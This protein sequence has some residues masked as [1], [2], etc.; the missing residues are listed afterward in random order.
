MEV[1][2][3]CGGGDDGLRCEKLSGGGMWRCNLMA[4]SG[5]TLCVKHSVSVHKEV[6]KSQKMG[7]GEFLPGGFKKRKRGEELKIGVFN[8]VRKRPKGLK[9]KMKNKV[10]VQND[11]GIKI[12]RRGRPKG[13]KNK[14]KIGAEAMKQENGVKN[15][16]VSKVGEISEEGKV[17]DIFQDVGPAPMVHRRRVGRPKGSKNKK[18][19]VNNCTENGDYWGDNVSR[20][21]VRRMGRPKGSK[22]KKK[23]VNEAEK[24][25][26]NGAAKQG[27]GVGRPKGYNNHKMILSPIELTR[28]TRNYASDGDIQYLGRT[29]SS[30]TTK[31]K[32]IMKEDQENIDDRDRILPADIERLDDASVAEFMLK[33]KNKRDD[34]KKKFVAVEANGVGLPEEDE[35]YF[36]SSE[37]KKKGRG[38]PKKIRIE[39]RE[40]NVGSQK[41]LAENDDGVKKR[42]R[43]RPKKNVNES[44]DFACMGEEITNG[45]VKKTVLSGSGMSDPTVQ[46]EQRGLMCHQCLKSS[47]DDV[48]ICSNCNKKRYCSECIAKWYPKKTKE[49]VEKSCP[50]CCGNCNCRAC[51]QADVLL[52]GCQ[53]EADENIRLQRSLYLL[54][55]V[56]PLLRLIQLEQTNELDV[57]TSIRGV[58]MNEEDVQVAVCEEDDRVYCD[59]CKTSIV[60]FHRSCASAACS[61]DI[62]LDCCHELRKGLQPGGI[63]AKSLPRPAE[64]TLEIKNLSNDNNIEAPKWEAMNNGSI[65]CPPEAHGGCGTHILVLKR[66]FD[67]NWV[68]KLIRAAEEFT[69]NYQLPDIDFSRKCLSCV[70]GDEFCEVRKAADRE[71]SEDNFLYCPDAL[72]MGDSAF[73]HFQMHWRKGEPVIVRNALSRASGLSWEPMVMLRAFR[74][75]SKKLNQD[76]F[77]VK[78][79]DC[80]D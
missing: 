57:E 13:S 47:K 77:C 61:Y 68:Q 66:I 19:R 29:K 31:S 53:E 3:V 62:C 23:K 28:G 76:V 1:S 43:G 72:D 44:Y 40:E 59:N 21:G 39:E 48:A 33:R 37:V 70:T 46:R 15:G 56:L 52:Q 71:C 49:E 58:Q 41:E 50:F 16:D 20:N 67:A 75:A 32:R 6:K 79:I 69:L 17:F 7:T 38:R 42:A 64:T 54:F 14:P 78:A 11:G 45:G 80:L 74:N 25:D 27:S 4:M 18:E 60:N 12:E 73:E 63:G 55:H 9:N 51:L 2:A 35:I 34:G 10:V 8:C 5:K 65:T 36:Y 22:N 26:G 24:S 30:K